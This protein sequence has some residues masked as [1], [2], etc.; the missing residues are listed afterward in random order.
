MEEVSKQSSKVFV[1]WYKKITHTLYRNTKT[2]MFIAEIL[3]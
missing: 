1:R 2:Q 3:E